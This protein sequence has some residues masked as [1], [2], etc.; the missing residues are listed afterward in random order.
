LSNGW[1]FGIIPTK[2]GS[3]I[4]GSKDL[5]LWLTGLGKSIKGG[6]IIC[7]ETRKSKDSSVL[8]I[9]GDYGLS[10]L[11]LCFNSILIKL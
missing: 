5:G 2:G 8:W 9:D 10:S 11:A 1:K 3:G 4:I 6:G 7:F